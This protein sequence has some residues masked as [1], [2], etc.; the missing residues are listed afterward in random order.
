[1]RQK[2]KTSNISY[3]DICSQSGR[4]KPNNSTLLNWGTKLR[5]STSRKL[6]PSTSYEYD[7]HNLK[8]SNAEAD[9]GGGEKVVLFFKKNIYMIF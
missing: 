5:R 7:Y 2:K 9:L 8:V 1:M 4:L 3:G 6:A